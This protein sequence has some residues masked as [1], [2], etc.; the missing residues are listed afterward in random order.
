MLKPWICCDSVTSRRYKPFQHQL[1]ADTSWCSTHQNWVKNHCFWDIP[2]PIMK[3]SEEDYNTLYAWVVLSDSSALLACHSQPALTAVPFT[4]G[5]VCITWQ[6]AD[7]LRGFSCIYLLCQLQIAHRK[8]TL[9]R[10]S[11]CMSLEYGLWSCCCL[12]FHTV[13]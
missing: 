1:A 8:L 13:W 9:F 4:A 11:D 7:C 10:F 2:C 12:H 5:S 3:V 6:I